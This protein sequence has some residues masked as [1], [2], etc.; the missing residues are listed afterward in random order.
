MSTDPL[1]CKQAE[2]LSERADRLV[3]EELLTAENERLR[4]EVAT[5]RSALRA[6]GRVALPYA[7]DN[8]PPRRR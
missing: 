6:V 4:R 8:G 1:S 7:T 2:M 5:L 3:A